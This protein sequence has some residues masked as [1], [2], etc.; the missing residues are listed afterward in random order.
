MEKFAQSSCRLARPMMV[1]SESSI[2][3]D[4]PQKHLYVKA[5]ELA[6]EEENDDQIQQ[7][8]CNVKDEPA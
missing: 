3:V 2:E 8:G 4:K 7:N 1:V 6:K 5:R